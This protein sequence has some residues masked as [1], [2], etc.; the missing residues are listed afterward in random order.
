MLEAIDEKETLAS[1]LETYKTLV[2]TIRC[3]FLAHRVL[4]PPA[5]PRRSDSRA[6]LAHS[7][8]PPQL[9]PQVSN[10]A[11]REDTLTA[12]ARMQLSSPTPSCARPLRGGAHRGLPRG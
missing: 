10:D 7:L 11:L 3:A 12:L 2:P 9:Q 8:I 5:R 4:S 6:Q 1:A